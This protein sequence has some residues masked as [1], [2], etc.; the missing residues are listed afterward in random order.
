VIISLDFDGVLHDPYNRVDGHKMGRPVHGAR[1]ACHALIE[2]G[3]TLYVNS[4]RFQHEGD[5]AHVSDWLEYFGF[6][7]GNRGPGDYKGMFPRIA[8]A[9]AD[10]YV[11]DRALH[12]VAWPE[13]MAQLRQLDSSR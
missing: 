12:F 4:A 8:K 9:V 1:E 11:D 10:V 6:P 3:H 2:Q 7:V 5:T 13:A